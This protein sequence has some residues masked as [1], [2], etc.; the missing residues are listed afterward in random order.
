VDPDEAPAPPVEAD[1]PPTEFEPDLDQE[2]LSILRM[3]EQGQIT[4]QDAE[5]LLDALM[6]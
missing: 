5:M 2:R 4:P 6:A 3:V 1:E